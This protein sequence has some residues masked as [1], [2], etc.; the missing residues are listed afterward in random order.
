[1]KYETEK[2][3][4]P[5]VCRWL[6]NFLRDRF[7]KAD[8]EVYELSKSRSLV[9]LAHITAEISRVNGLHGISKWISSGLYINQINRL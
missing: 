5:D 4:Y 8:V 6:E 3:M 1:M 7:K 2:D 9:F